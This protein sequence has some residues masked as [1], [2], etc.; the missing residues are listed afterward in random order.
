MIWFTKAIHL[1]FN[2]MVFLIR[3]ILKNS[4]HFNHQCKQRRI[5]LFRKW[6]HNS[7]I[8]WKKIA[9]FCNE[10]TWNSCR[11]IDFFAILHSFE[12]D[13]WNVINVFF[14]YVT[15]F[16]IL[17]NIRNKNWEDWIHSPAKSNTLYRRKIP[18]ML[19]C[20]KKTCYQLQI[21]CS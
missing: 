19:C 9:V 14:V 3:L 12:L 11:F 20:Q 7:Y 21:N 18:F 16:E 15:H 10:K 13:L 6:H 8:H 2:E 5:Y 4:L 1:L 17:I